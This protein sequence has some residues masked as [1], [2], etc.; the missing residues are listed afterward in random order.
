M[1]CVCSI[2]RFF[3]LARS[4][5]DAAVAHSDGMVDGSVGSAEFTYSWHTNAA[6]EKSG[7]YE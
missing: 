3:A 1:V 4:V 7:R 2:Q 6:E 5:P